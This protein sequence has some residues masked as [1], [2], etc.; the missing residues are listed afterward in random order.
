MEITLNIQSLTPDIIP[1]TNNITDYLVN[2]TTD[3]QGLLK[4]T[5]IAHIEDLASPTDRNWAPIAYAQPTL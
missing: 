2:I 1:L 5:G 4:E 3:Q